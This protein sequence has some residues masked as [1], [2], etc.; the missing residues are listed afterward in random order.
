[1]KYWL[2][3]RLS[4]GAR[5]YYM[6]TVLHDWPDA[7]AVKIG[8]GVFEAMKPGYSRFLVHENVIPP[9]SPDDEQTT[10]DLIMM[11]NYAGKER[12]AAQWSELLEEK[13][14]FKI[15]KTWT[16]I[17]G[18]ESVIECERPE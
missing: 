17:D 6:H 12:T 18:I 16:P 4:P 8:R 11:T 5:V 7:E 14:G 3:D 2:I 1:M 15:V 9:M 13:C 10:L